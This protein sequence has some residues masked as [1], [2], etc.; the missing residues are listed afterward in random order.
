MSSD[1]GGVLVKPVDNALASLGWTQFGGAQN[2]G[3]QPARC[4]FQPSPAR[5]TLSNMPAFLL[6]S[7]LFVFVSAL[8]MLSP[9]STAAQTAVDL[10]LVLAV[11]V[12]LSMD[13]DEQR[14][15]RDGYVQALRDPE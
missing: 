13:M 5:A 14:L 11:D 7:L 12:S 9:E 2:V 10:E 4:A 6:K 3:L 15:Q 1:N 8:W